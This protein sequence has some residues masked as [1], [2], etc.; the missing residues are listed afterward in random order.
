MGKNKNRFV[1]AIRSSQPN[2]GLSIYTSPEGL[3]ILYLFKNRRSLLRFL[4]EQKEDLSEVAPHKFRVANFTRNFWEFFEQIEVDAIHYEGSW[5]PLTKEGLSSMID[6]EDPELLDHTLWGR[7]F[8]DRDQEGLKAVS[9]LWW[10]LFSLQ[11]IDL[12]PK[13]NKEEEDIRN[14]NSSLFAEDKR[15]SRNWKDLKQYYLPQ[16]VPEELS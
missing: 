9:V 6:G 5:F 15:L 12:F 14:I 7:S 13:I 1:Y 11:K 2:S 10:S 3:K 16:I 8:R 4:K